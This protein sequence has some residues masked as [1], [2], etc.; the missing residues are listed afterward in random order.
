MAVVSDPPARSGAVDLLKTLAII[1]VVMIHVSAESI[2]SA[3]GSPDWYASVFWGSLVRAA[4]PIFFMCSGALLLDPAKDVPIRRVYGKYLPRILAAL[5]FWAAA[6]ALLNLSRQGP[7]SS[8]A[9]WQAVKELLLFRHHFQLYFLHILL[10]IYILLPVT[11]LLA[12]APKP[13]LRYA[14]ALWFILGV[15]LPF[16]RPYY[17]FDLLKGIPAQYALSLTWS[18]AGYSL[19]GHYL[20]QYPPKRASRCLLLFLLGFVITFAGTTLSSLQ[21]GAYAG[22]FNEAL[23]PGVCFM[24][25]GLFGWAFACGTRPNRFFTIAAQAS[26]CVYLVHD[27]FNIWRRDWTLTANS[28]PAALSIPALSAGVL[29]CSFAVWMVLSRIP[30]VKRYLI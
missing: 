22:Q 18:A 29:L 2:I 3:V 9:L 24:A 12:A 21:Q 26:F 11:R 10:L 13:L 14:L 15:A 30:V 27:F 6:Y 8:G 25:A 16:A 28:F 19:L 7:L 20:R 4:V 17:P 5:F 23:S 1:G